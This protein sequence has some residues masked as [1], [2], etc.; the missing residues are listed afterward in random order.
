MTVKTENVDRLKCILSAGC[1]K[2]G[3][4]NR[5]LRQKH[6][7]IRSHLV[8]TDTVGAIESVLVDGVSVLSGLN[9]EKM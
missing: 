3:S 8:S 4:K 5:L 6:N 7:M 2:N 1:G 9:L